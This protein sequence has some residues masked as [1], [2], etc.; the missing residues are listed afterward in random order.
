VNLV[1]TPRRKETIFLPE[2][3]VLVVA[4][5][6]FY[7]DRGTPIAVSQLL[8]ALS[9][10]SYEVDV[11]TYPIGR[12]L[13]I[14][15]VRY[16]RGAN[17]LGL[18]RVPVGFSFR[19]LVLDATLIPELVRRLSSGTYRCIHALEESAF[20][21]VVLG[22][23]FG[24]PVIYDM[25]SSLPEQLAARLMFRVPP[26]PALLRWMERWLLRRADSVVSSAGLAERVR[27]VAPG[28]RLR[29]WEYAG[30]LPPVPAAEGAAL[31]R[32]LGIGAVQPLVVYCGTF[33]PYQGLP[34]LL[35]A[36]PL[37]RAEVPDAAFVLVGAAE[38]G[39]DTVSRGGSRAHA[40]LVRQ[41]ALRVVRRQPRERIPRFLAMADVVV[42]PRAYGDNLPLKVFDYLTAGKAIVATDIPAHRSILDEETAVLTGLGSAEIA[43]GIVRLLRDPELAARLGAA[44]RAFAEQRLGWFS[45]VRSVSE[46][47]GELNGGHAGVGG[48]GGIGGNGNGSHGH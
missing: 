23:R 29:E 1:W 2:S 20:L 35:A 24:V 8:R 42:S 36:I 46:L 40:E 5:E 27:A 10:L 17:P 22:R 4:P 37:V 32:E 9:Q 3:R 6:P 13:E 11:L 26:V 15:R 33:E 16:F 19:K 28:V 21:A 43:R 31:R 12:S 25:Q 34:E 7:E 47:Y 39:D 48:L 14:P 38:A 18:R 41:G 30:S 44:G 45:F